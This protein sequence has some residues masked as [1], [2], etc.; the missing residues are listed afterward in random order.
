MCFPLFAL[1]GV[2]GVAQDNAPLRATF[3]QGALHA[4]L[5]VRDDNGKVIGT[6]DEVNVRAGNV[7]RGRLTLHFHDGSIDDETAVYTQHTTLRLV[8]DHHVQKGPSFPKPMDMTIDMG[9]QMVTWH[10]EKDG[11]DEVKTDH[12]KLPASLCNGLLPQIVQN[13]PRGVQ[14]LKMGYIAAT[15]KPRVVTLNVHR[16][17]LDKFNLAG[18]GRQAAKYR[19]HVELGGIAGV[20][21]PIIGK[22]PPDMY[23]WAVEGDVPTFLRLNG[24]LFE[25]GPIWNLELSSPT[26]P[27]GQ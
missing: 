25:G 20:V 16:D 10:E 18:A 12:M 15:P 13:M 21:A 4:F 22:E 14:E 1:L 6:G 23:I 26:W 3:Q 27:T 7:W 2:G 9:K 19:V 17:G 8:S 11:R 5:V 24:F